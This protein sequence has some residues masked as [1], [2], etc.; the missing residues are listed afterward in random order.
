MPTYDLIYRGALHGAEAWAYSCAVTGSGTL[1]DAATA[2]TD[3]ATAMFAAT[4]F[5]DTFHTGVTWVDVLINQ[6]PD[7]GVGPVIDSA[8]A[9]FADAGVS[10]AG[11]TPNQ[12]AIVV[13]KQTGF[14][15]SRNR[16]RMYLPPPAV[17]ALT[18]AGRIDAI[19]LV[20]LSNGL[21]AWK[22][23]LIGDGFTPVLVSPSQNANVVI[24]TLRIGNV[25]D[26]MRSRRNDLVESYTNIS[27]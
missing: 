24:T 11:S 15:G 3:A 17:D 19:A 4:D 23:S 22:N 5:D 21:T 25:V 12:C 8:V 2:A 10:A 9:P 26:T 16:G 14:A 20:G 13:S 1:S 18:T 27:V 7:G 6:I